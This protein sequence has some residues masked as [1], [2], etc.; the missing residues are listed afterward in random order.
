MKEREKKIRLK[1]ERLLRG[2]KKNFAGWLGRAILWG[3][4]IM[5]VLCF[6]ANISNHIPVLDYLVREMK[7]PKAYSLNGI[8]E[9]EGNISM[10]TN[11]I[12]ICIGAY[13]EKVNNGQDFSI[14]FSGIIDEEIPVVIIYECEDVK[15]Q[16]IKYI[17]YKRHQN[18]LKVNWKIKV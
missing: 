3:T 4:A 18:K 1:K 8:I 9:V 13:K 6:C 15:K 12:Y 10:E 11:E 5:F 7:M 2:I 14:N 16:D 17:S